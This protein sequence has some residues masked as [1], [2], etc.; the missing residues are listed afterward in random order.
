LSTETTPPATLTFYVWVTTFDTSYV[1]QLCAKLV[2]RGFMVGA[3]GR[4]LI[5]D[6]ESYATS[7][8]AISLHRP[9]RGDEEK[10]EYTAVGVHAE[11]TDVLRAMKAK[12]ASI[13]VSIAA[14]CTWNIG[15]ERV[16]PEQRVVELTKKL[17]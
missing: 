4:R 13:V 12:Y 15:N 14:G 11:V 8:I 17:N 2:K 10:R 6:H 3:M 1:D 16:T 5:T 7:V 9:P